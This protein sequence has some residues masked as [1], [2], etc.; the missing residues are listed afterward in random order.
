MFVA[1]P[2]GF[3][4]RFATA[5]VEVLHALRDAE[6]LEGVSAVW[7]HQP[8]TER[9]LKMLLILPALILRRTHTPHGRRA[10]AAFHTLGD[11]RVRRAG[12]RLVA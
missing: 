8:E 4:E 1:L 12:R 5:F 7:V 11:A 6:A 10:R 3:A 2:P 9:A